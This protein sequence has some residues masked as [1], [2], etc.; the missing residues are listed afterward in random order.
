MKECVKKKVLKRDELC[1]QQLRFT[2]MFC[3]R[4]ISVV[5]IWISFQ[6]VSVLNIWDLKGRLQQQVELLWGMH[7]HGDAEDG[8]RRCRGKEETTWF[9]IE[10][11]ERS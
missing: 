10:V 7:A 1:S 6:N 9:Y 11:I 5:N 2:T 8:E 4:A 3:S